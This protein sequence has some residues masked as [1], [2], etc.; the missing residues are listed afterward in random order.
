MKEY[1]TDWEKIFI[2]CLSDKGLV[3]SCIKAL[4]ELYKTK[5]KKKKQLHQNKINNHP[6]KK[7]IQGKEMSRNFLKEDKWSKVYYKCFAALII[8][9]HQIKATVIYYLT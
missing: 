3:S 2:H 7:Q 5:S 6:P 8:R 4:V 9:E 1:P